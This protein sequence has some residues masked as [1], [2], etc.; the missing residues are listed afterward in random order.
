MR[1]TRVKLVN[2][3]PLV[4]VNIP[5][6]PNVTI[7]AYIRAGARLDPP[8]KAGLAHF[9]EHMLFNGTEEYPNRRQ[10]AYQ[11]EQFGGW[12]TAFTWIDY[13]VHEIHLPAN[14]YK[15]GIEVL[16][17]TLFA[18]LFKEEEIEKEKGVIEEEILR[19]K[20]DPEKA[21]LEYA[22]QPLFF[23]GSLLCR[24]YSGTL[25]EISS[26]KRADIV[27]FV[28]NFLPQQIVFLIAGSQDSSRVQSVFEKYIKIYQLKAKTPKNN[29]IKIKRD[30]KVNVVPSNS[31]IV[32]L[33][34]GLETVDIESNNRYIIDLIKN[35]LCRDFGA[36]LPE[37]LRDQ[38]GLIY[39]WY[40]FHDNLSDTGYLL[41]KTST[42]KKN[43]L[44]V[45]Q[46][47]IEEFERIAQG[48]ISDEELEI[49]RKH[50]IGSLLTNI[51]TGAD[52]IRWYG[53]QELLI[54]QK[55]LHINDQV[56]IYKRISKERIIETAK[57]YFS[58]KKTYI[59]AY[60]DVKAKDLEELLH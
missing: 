17:E 43:Y 55:V 18:S 1:Y 41:F 8:K 10:L 58:K 34:V 36:S 60:G 27:D 56:K 53:V 15:H 39:T 20:S 5:E 12:H 38:G 48:E 33:A 29:Y 45:S 59:A 28:A 6:S 16:M 30:K 11:I 13:Q 46:L 37:K 40:C 47:I 9:T 49:A 23:Q 32:S 21:V 3:S 25:E 52:Y 35:M 44:K 26:V 42:N 54:P 24:P 7:A 50:S 31:E 51:E 57:K 22:W 4:I 2:E 14:K 19:N